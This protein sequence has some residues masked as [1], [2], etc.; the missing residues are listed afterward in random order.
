MVRKCYDDPTVRQG[1]AL[2]ASRRASDLLDAARSALALL[3][4]RAPAGVPA[5]D[6]ERVASR[7]AELL[8]WAGGWL[9]EPY[10]PRPAAA[11]AGADGTL[12]ALAQLTDAFE[13]LVEAL[14]DDDP[15]RNA[16]GVQTGSLAF[17]IVSDAA[18]RLRRLASAQGRGRR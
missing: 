10:R 15:V 2:D 6:A 12:A 7:A 8:V 16:N 9:D 4:R 3:A 18:S 5:A 1:D 17:A 14:E 11:V 13:E